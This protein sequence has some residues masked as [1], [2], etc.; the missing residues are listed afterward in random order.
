MVKVK[1][2]L[3]V[4]MHAES[5]FGLYFGR[6]SLSSKMFQSFLVVTQNSF[7]WLFGARY[8]L[9]SQNIALILND[10]ECNC[11]R[12]ILERKIRK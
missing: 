6:L 3:E 10:R 9:V 7:C 2:V 8:F 5:K 4:L 11:L 12:I 1:A